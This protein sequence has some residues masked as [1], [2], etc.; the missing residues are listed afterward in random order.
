MWTF[1]L[2]NYKK[3][4]LLI[5]YRLNFVAC[6]GYFF[7][8]RSPVSQIITEW[9]WKKYFVIKHDWPQICIKIACDISNGNSSKFQW[10]PIK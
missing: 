10:I 6:V 3:Q 4:K 7:L 1:L 5:N 9:L 2:L 8:F